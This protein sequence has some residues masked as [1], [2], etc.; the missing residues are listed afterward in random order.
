MK[1]YRTSQ[2]EQIERVSREAVEWLHALKADPGA[3]EREAF[4]SWLASSPV[5]VR[6]MLLA[7]MLDREL[8]GMS[9]LDRFD[10]E[11]IVARAKASENVVSLPVKAPR[12]PAE[13]HRHP[14]PRHGL[15]WRRAAAVAA[16]FLL[17]L[18][19]WLGTRNYLGSGA[20]YATAIGEQRT[21]TLDDGTQV[22]LAADSRISVDFSP[23]YRRVTLRRGEAEFDV[24]HDASRPFRVYAGANMIQ[25]VGTRFSV[26][27]LPSGTIVS[28]IEGMVQVSVDHLAALDGG[29]G[30]WAASW[31]PAKVAAIKRPGARVESLNR[32]LHLGAGQTAHIA[33][34]GE[35]LT[36]SHVDEES[37]SP[38]NDGR[39]TFHNDTLADIAAEFNR[40]NARQIVVDGNAARLQRYSGVFD[41]ND[42]ASF[43]QF[44]DC[45]STLTAV[46]EGDHTVI[47]PRPIA[48]SSAQ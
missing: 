34:N 9:V 4:A 36:R 13:V 33:R 32:P 23:G 38:A 42:S 39:L 11:A 6:E 43:L 26:N 17:G 2:Q 44:L 1:I 14:R 12:K 46:R 22:E 30:A 29:I 37:Q 28:V 10:V 35:A 18:T 21:I 3:A 31:L 15:P 45:C 48:P 5:H 8:S 16:V 25:D 7:G 41:A 20:E 24:V 47:R 27:R 19:G 40:Y